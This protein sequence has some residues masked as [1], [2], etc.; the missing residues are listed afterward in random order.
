MIKYVVLL[1]VVMFDG[2]DVFSQVEAVISRHLKA[3]AGQTDL[4]GINESLANGVD[5]DGDEEGNVSLSMVRGVGYRYVYDF[6]FWANLEVLRDSA[7]IAAPGCNGG[8]RTPLAA[9]EFK[10]IDFGFEP[11]D[12]FVNYKQNGYTVRLDSQSVAI[13]GMSCSLVVMTSKNGNTRKYYID[14]KTGFIV[15]DVAK[16]WIVPICGVTDIQTDYYD[17]EQQ[18]GI[19]IAMRRERVA[20]DNP[21]DA[22]VIE[23]IEFKTTR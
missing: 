1:A 11:V 9:E 16:Q 5:V 7:W 14:N 13:R 6:L 3:V 18:H 10:A 15:R 22:I 19:M 4:A 2:V 12:D 8:F 21:I 20:G 17:F 23:K